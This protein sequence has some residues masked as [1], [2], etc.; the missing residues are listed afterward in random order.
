MQPQLNHLVANEHIAGLRR[1]AER[2][3]FARGA[4]HESLLTRV[5]TSLRGRGRLIGEH[6]PAR[7]SEAESVA[8]AAVDAPAPAEA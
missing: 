6:A 8:P 7:R 4:K 2:E 1:A 3:R 5:I